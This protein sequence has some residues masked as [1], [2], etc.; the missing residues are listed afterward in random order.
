MKLREASG[1][2]LWYMRLCGFKGWASFWET[3]YVVPGHLTDRRLVRHELCHL[4]QIE[5]DGRLVFTVKYLWWL[6]LL[7][8]WNNPYE[9]AAREAEERQ[10]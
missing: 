1:P 10:P 3:I 8:Y 7:G 5:R 4:E 6:L 9:I 2:I